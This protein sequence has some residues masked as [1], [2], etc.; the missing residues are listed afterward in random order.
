MRPADRVFSP[1]EIMAIGRS[2]LASAPYEWK[3]VSDHLVKKRRSEI[4]P[5]NG[6]S[7]SITNNEH[8]VSCCTLSNS[9]PS[10]SVSR[11]AMPE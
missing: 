11:C 3:D 1:D 7:C 8:P 6:M 4:E 9:G 10:A 2:L 5:I